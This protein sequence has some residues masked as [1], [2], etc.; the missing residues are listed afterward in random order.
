ME[1]RDK[2]YIG[3]AWVPSTGTGTLEVIDSNTEEVIG[4]IP[5]GTRRGRRP[6]GRRRRPTPSRSGRPRSVEERAKLL[7][8]VGEALGART[9]EIADTHLPGGRHAL[10]AV[11]PDPG[12]SAG[13][14]LRRGGTAGRGL[15]VGG[16]DRQLARR[17]RAGRGGRRHHAVELPALPDRPE[18]GAGPGRRLHR[19]AQAERGGS[20]QR[21]RPGRGHRRDRAARRRLQPGDRGRP[22]RGRG[23][24]L[25]PPGRHGVVHRLDPGRQAGHGSWPPR[26]SSGSPSSSAASRPTSSS[27]TPTSTRPC[28]RASSPATSTRARPARPSPG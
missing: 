20:A 24:R 3:G 1:V 16:G 10:H 12:R 15:H 13:R 19:G 17:A 25:A 11:G 9:D 6:G 18:G 28:R 26:R 23:H 4:T 5:D 14:C 7:T 8:R 22:G 21:L 2:L 27:R